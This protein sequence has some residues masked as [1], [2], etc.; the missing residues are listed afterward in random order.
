MAA[1][2]HAGPR[3]LLNNDHA[4][5]EKNLANIIPT[6]RRSTARFAAVARGNSAY[7]ARF[8]AVGLLGTLLDM[9]LFGLLHLA[10]GL[11]AL[12]ANTLSYSAGIVNNFLLHRRWTYA[13]SARRPALGQFARFT[14]VSLSA[15]ALNTLVVTLLSPAL[16]QSLPLPTAALAA[17][18]F[19]TGLG[20][21]WNFLANHLWTFR[22]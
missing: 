8:A 5:F 16:A 21:A 7:L 2:P 18:V 22:G 1:I 6:A 14:A 10:L 15:L 4:P 13:P 12:P 20:I 11:A 9:A 3:P 17:K 19:A